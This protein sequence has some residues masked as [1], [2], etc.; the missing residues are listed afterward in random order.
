M[1]VIVEKMGKVNY[2]KVQCNECESILK[3]ISIKDEKENYEPDGYLGPS[4]FFYI[5]CPLCGNKVVTRAFVGNEMIDY[6]IFD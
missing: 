4:S 2:N 6:R 1:A 5:K 3:Y